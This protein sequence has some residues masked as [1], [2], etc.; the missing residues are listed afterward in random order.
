MALIDAGYKRVECLRTGIWQRRGVIAM[1]SLRACLEVPW[2]R[3]FVTLAW[4]MCLVQTSILFL[5]GQLLVP[6]GVIGDV[7]KGLGGPLRQIA[8]GLMAWLGAN[9][10]ISV[11]TIYNILFFFFS[12]ILSTV[13]YFAVALALPHLITRD[14]SSN[15]I[16]VYSSKAVNRFDY[17]LGKFAALFGV[18]TLTWLGPLCV[19]WFLGNA[20]SPNWHFFW[21]SRVALFHTLIY[22]GTSMVFLT[23][24]GLGVSALSPK[25]KSTVSVW[26]SFWILGGA[27]VALGTISKGWLKH[28]S[29][30]YNLEQI[31]IATF[32]LRNEIETAAENVPGVKQ[33][34]GQF[35]REPELT[36]AIIGLSVMAAAAGAVVW[37]KAKPE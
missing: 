10:D 21:H 3:R 1:N 36:G 2:M 19:A 23:V 32:D 25:E 30:S 34:I 16:I 22:V 13:S 18:L 37:R 14:L 29:F 15:A 7:V 31:A 35:L 24:M 28:F 12:T 4:I 9:P 17:V 8:N 27:F 33:T 6:G 26:I 11:H 20:L 5:V